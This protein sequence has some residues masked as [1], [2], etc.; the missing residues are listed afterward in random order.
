MKYLSALPLVGV[1]AWWGLQ[2]VRA[3]AMPSEW[4]WDY[5]RTSIRFRRRARGRSRRA[6]TTA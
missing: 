6:L 3:R 1:A 2:V 5:L 4:Q